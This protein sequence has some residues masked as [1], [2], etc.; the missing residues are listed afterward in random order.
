MVQAKL[1]SENE[2]HDRLA[3]N[4]KHE[5]YLD[6]ILKVNG[7]ERKKIAED[8][9]C[10]FRSVLAQCDLIDACQTED[11]NV[12]AFRSLCSEYIHSNQEMWSHWIPNNDMVNKIKQ[13]KKRGVWNTDIMDIMPYVVLDM[14]YCNFLIFQ[15][16]E[17]LNIKRI[18]PRTSLKCETGLVLC[19]R[20]AHGREHYDACM[21]SNTSTVPLSFTNIAIV[22]HSNN[23]V[24]DVQ[25]R[26]INEH[27]LSIP[28][29]AADVPP[30]AE[31]FAQEDTM[32][33]DVAARVSPVNVPLAESLAQEDT[34]S[35]AI[36]HVLPLNVLQAENLTSEGTVISDVA[37]HVSSF[38]I[39]QAESLAQE[40]TMISDAHWYD[41]HD[42]IGK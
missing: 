11:E 38:D 33:S 34:I 4:I 18:K 31:S 28:K 21:S 7:Y 32:I 22:A 1:R 19:C 27:P 40:D 37:D 8:G 6:R 25:Q 12:A 10:F 23:T 3:E 24:T 20:L 9:D 30:L 17:G 16:G 5:K 26:S 35:G 29:A 14:L 39:P 42:S 41:W 15:S 2:Y 36:A 13:V